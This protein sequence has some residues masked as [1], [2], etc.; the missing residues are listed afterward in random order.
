MIQSVGIV[1]G[2]I[3]PCSKILSSFAFA[4]GQVK[5]G[6]CYGTWKTEHTSLHSELWYVCAKCS[7]SLKA[8]GEFTDDFLL[9]AD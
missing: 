3:T 7:N 2:P 5:I 6:H 9:C 1:T 4:N 8:T